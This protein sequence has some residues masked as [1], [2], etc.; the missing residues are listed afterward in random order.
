MRILQMP[1]DLAKKCTLVRDSYESA[2][3]ALRVPLIDLP[4]EQRRDFYANAFK[5]LCGCAIA[6]KD[7]EIEV[8]ETFNISGF[9]KIDVDKLYVSEE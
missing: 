8:L 1:D 9:E 5:D 4:I 7:V 6:N 2:L 3:Q